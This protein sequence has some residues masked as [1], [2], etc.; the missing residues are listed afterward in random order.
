[1]EFLRAVQKKS[2]SISALIGLCI[3]LLHVI[4]EIFPLRNL[5]FTGIY[6]LTVFE[7]WMGGENTSVYPILY[8]F[9]AP[10]LIAFPYV[11]SLK[12]DLRSG[13]CNQIFSRTKSSHYFTAKYLVTFFTTGF[14]SVLPLIA[15]FLLCGLFLPM[16]MPQAGTSFYSIFGTSFLG[17]LFYQKP[18]VYLLIYLVIDFSYFGLLSTLGLLAAYFTENYLVM[19]LSPFLAYLLLYALTQLTMLY[20]FCPY[21]FLRPGQ[22]VAAEP[23]VLIIE[24]AAL[25]LI[26]C[27]YFYVSQKEHLE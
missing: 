13:Y 2:S 21:G 5:I 12:Q 17:D 14:L 7:K 25:L 8:Y 10:V 9:I 26:G 18:L 22:P 20:R 4:T 6:P 1:M 27:V 24:Y 3:A 11:G 16:A 15:N 23:F 19:V